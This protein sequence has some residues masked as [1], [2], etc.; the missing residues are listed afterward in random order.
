M[1]SQNYV[2]ITG[3]SS[4]IGRALAVAFVRCG[5]SVVLVARREAMLQGLK[6]ELMQLNPQ[7]NVEIRVCDLSAPG[8]A[9]ALY[10]SLSDLTIITWINNAGFGYYGSVAEQSVA[11][12]EKLIALNVNALM[13]LSALYVQDYQH[14]DGVQLINISS[15]GGYTI[16][17]SA[18]TYCASKFFV[19]AYTE[20][21]ARELIRSGAKLRAKVL[22]P[23]ATQTAFGQ[24]AN[25]VD[26][27]D[28]DAVFGR[29]HTSGQMAEFA[30]ELY[31]SDNITGMI[32][33]DDFS[34]QLTD[35]RFSHAENSSANQKITP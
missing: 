26:S 1:N 27:Y 19:S 23:A 17:P 32:D 20:G 9:A 11:E 6:A 13:V 35:T 12:A 8:S 14:V 29:Y 22:A 33:R 30:L 24:V 34:F 3:A 16:V 2:V 7:V 5:S 21:L 28:Y 15:A 25:K 10:H 31:D 4:G 18:V